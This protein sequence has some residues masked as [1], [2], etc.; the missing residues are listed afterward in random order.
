MSADQK[1][2]ETKGKGFFS[3]LSG[4]KKEETNETG[5]KNKKKKPALKK[6]KKT[7]DPGQDE[8]EEEQLEEEVLGGASPGNRFSVFNK[9]NEKKGDHKLIKNNPERGKDDK[10]SRGIGN[11]REN[12]HLKSQDGETYKDRGENNF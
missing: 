1:K 8:Q 3:F 5:E 6:A 11:G 9:E 10:E 2:K 12:A 7:G 4:K